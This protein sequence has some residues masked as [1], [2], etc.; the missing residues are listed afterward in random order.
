[1]KIKDSF[2]QDDCI[3][4]PQSTPLRVI[5]LFAPF[6]Q[7]FNSRHSCVHRTFQKRERNFN[8]DGIRVSS[9]YDDV[10]YPFKSVTL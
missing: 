9:A 8:K 4:L 2:F 3:A 7:L 1:M 10:N 6:L 5:H